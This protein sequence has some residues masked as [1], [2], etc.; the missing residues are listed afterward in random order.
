MDIAVSGVTATT[1]TV[2]ISAGTA[3]VPL[4]Y[5]V[6]YSPG[7]SFCVAPVIAAG[8]LSGAGGMVIA[9]SGLNQDSPFYFRAREI[10]ASVA[11]PWS[12][13]VGFV[14]PVSVAPST[15]PAAVMIEPAML[16]IPSPVLAWAADNVVSGYPVANLGRD[17]PVA[18]RSYAAGDIH[19]FEVR[20]APGK[21][22][23]IALLMSNA[24]EAATV[25]I[26]AGADAAN[27]NG[28]SPSFTTAALPFRASANIA[29]RPGYHALI[30]LPA[31]QSYPY[32]RI[33]I[34]APIGPGHVFHLEHA[35]LGLNRKSKN[36]ALDKVETPLDQGTLER[37]RSGNPARVRG[38]RMRRVDFELSVMK[39]ADYELL[40][41]DIARLVGSTD[42]VLAV[43]NTRAGA[44]LHDRILYGVIAGGRILNPASPRFTRGFTI[45]SIIA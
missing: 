5:Q 17:A 28:G 21:V 23:T 20:I 45:E 8:N 15:A 40:Y 32:W 42:P 11:G 31:T 13:T 1:A 18:W 35:I 14:T 6:S 26:R 27:V 38:I 25:T 41:H 12:T 9:L 3:S 36:Y 29:G 33:I 10:I 37:T 24:P 2:T 4:E 39:E 43:P 7:F 44:F 19:A 22:D 16:V 30:R 34:N